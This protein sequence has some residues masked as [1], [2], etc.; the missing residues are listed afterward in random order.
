MK[1]IT[2]VYDESRVI[3]MTAQVVAS[4]TSVI[5]MTL[6]VSFML[7]ENINSKGITIDLCRTSMAS[8]MIITYDR[9][10]IFIVQA[11]GLARPSVLLT[12]YSE[13]AAKVRICLGR[14]F[15]FKL[16]HFTL[17]LKK[18]GPNKY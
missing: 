10:N 1:H 7:L 3:R 6:E 17:K 4:L 12:A 16:G 5:L 8:L 14:V 11:T 15:N 18:L 9:Q 13:K 2:I